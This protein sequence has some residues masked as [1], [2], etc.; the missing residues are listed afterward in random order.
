M[1]NNHFLFIVLFQG[2]EI[3]AFFKPK[4][5]FSTNP[6]KLILSNIFH[7]KFSIEAWHLEWFIGAK[8]TKV[9]P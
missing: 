1:S 9:A 2:L 3:W 5:M 4:E 6:L 7:P 8:V